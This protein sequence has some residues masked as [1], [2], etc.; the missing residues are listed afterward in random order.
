MSRTE[1]SRISAMG[2]R[3]SH[4]GGRGGNR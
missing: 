4:G 2:G 3:A 1:R